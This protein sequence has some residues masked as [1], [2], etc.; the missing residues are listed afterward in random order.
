MDSEQELPIFG[1]FFLG[2]P[3]Q[4]VYRWEISKFCHSA[5]YRKFFMLLQI[6]LAGMVGSRQV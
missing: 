4:D 6:S 3:G 1:Q 5:D 2:Y